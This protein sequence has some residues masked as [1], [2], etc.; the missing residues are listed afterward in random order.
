[1]L[2]LLSSCGISLKESNNLS[3]TITNLSANNNHSNNKGI[4]INEICS[5]NRYSFIDTYN[6]TSDWVELYNSSSIPEDL[7]GWGISNKKSNLYMFKF[8]HCVLN[9]NE[10]LIVVASGRTAKVNKG[11]YHLP[12][13]LSQKNGGSLYLSNKTN[14]IVS[15]SNYPGLKD[16]ISYGLLGGEYK[17]TYPSPGTINEKQYIEKQILKMPTFSYPSGLYEKEFD[18]EINPPKGNEYKIYYTL[19]CSTPTLDAY[20]YQQ[21]IHIYDKSPEKNIISSRTDISA[22]NIPYV[23]TSPVK[24]CMVIKAICYDEQ[25]N[26]S[27]VASASYWINQGDFLQANISVMSISTDFDNLFG[28]ENGIYCNGKI[29]DDWLNSED[30]NPELAY[31]YQPANYI[32][33]GYEWERV[34][35]VSFIDAKGQAACEQTIGIR[36][37][38]NSSRGLSKKSF[39][40]YSR[41]NYDGNATFT[42]KF[43]GKKCEKLAIRNGGNNYSYIPTDAINSMV[44][45][46]NNLQFDTQ[47]STPT[48]LFLNGEFWGTYFL[49]DCYDS[50]YIK[51]KYGIEDSII[52]KSGHVEEGYKTDW[53]NITLAQN[54]VYQDMSNPINY[55]NFKNLIDIDSFIDEIIFYMYIDTYD[56]WLFSSN[57]VYWKSRSIDENIQKCDCLM[58][59]MLMDTDISY[60]ESFSVDHNPFSRDDFKDKLKQLMKNE[61]FYSKIYAK[62]KEIS[63]ILSSEETINM[64]ENYYSKVEYLIKQNSVRFYGIEEA[65]QTKRYNKLIDWYKNRSQYFVSFF[66]NTEF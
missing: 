41:Y 22:S 3:E 18:L 9:P 35:N 59:F 36:I 56:F 2:S 63:A 23:P 64:I 12:F 25:G 46:E 66:E 43:N 34:G 57:C 49:R 45:K 54:S 17:M 40:I 20:L 33:S 29:Y 15:Q 51:E 27:A 24:K 4:V 47:D 48:Y 26:Y 13:T 58:R 44:A 55:E 19:D 10:Y 8:D 50:R 16:D 38:G 65:G 53:T 28:Y 60:G 37:K 32:Q 6:E 11:E 52:I 42:Y 21:P 62:A 31:Y 61:E 1:M 14:I 5:K 7:T 30:Y 39:N